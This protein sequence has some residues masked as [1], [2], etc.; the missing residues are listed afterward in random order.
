MSK[1]LEI[2][3]YGRNR[4]LIKARK[5]RG[6]SLEDAA[7]GIGIG[8]DGLRRLEQGHRFGYWYTLYKISRFYHKSVDELFFDSL[9][10]RAKS[11][12]FYEY[13]ETPAERKERQNQLFKVDANGLN[14]VQAYHLR[15]AGFIK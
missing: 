10:D 1:K 13:I 3:R 2:G 15:Q 4:A 9:I 6:L 14:A 5:D 7:D 8:V 11:N 12:C